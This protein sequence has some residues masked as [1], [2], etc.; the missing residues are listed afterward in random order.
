MT[1]A[2][3]NTLWRGVGCAAMALFAVTPMFAAGFSIFEQGAKAM[4]M[5][6]AFT[7]QA[8]DPSAMFHNVGGLAFF[9]EQE[10]QLGFTYITHS[11]A[12]FR[13]ANPFPGEGVTEELKPLSETP[14]HFYWVQPLGD[15]WKFGLAVN[16]PFGLVTEW[17]NKSTFTGRFI[18]TRAALTAIDVNPNLGWKV[19]DTFGIGFGLILRASEVELNRRA[20][21]I[22]PFTLQPADVANVVLETDLD[23]GIGWQAGFLHRM[24]NSFSWGFSYRSEIEVDYGGQAVLSQVLTGNPQFDALVAQ[25]L[26]FGRDLPA[27]TSI[28]YPDAA[29]FGV[30]I[31]LSPRTMLEVDANWTGW[32]SFDRVLIDFTNDDL[33]D[34]LLPQEWDDTNH[35]RV[36]IRWTVSD[37]NEWRL[38][39]VY[40]ETPQPDTGVGPL[41]P[42]SDRNGITIGL[43]HRG[44]K[45]YWDLAVMYLPFDDRSTS[46]NRDGFDGSYEITAWLVGFSLGW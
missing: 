21:A 20:P 42:D 22:N 37:R 28:D 1:T 16:A 40:D 33:D 38:G 6:G 45:V 27:E 46:T 13:G 14:P 26:P 43:G 35:Y 17:E 39:Y 9:D 11:K 18:S 3:G 12:D 25:S 23:T 34:E 4:G 32:S 2:R 8:D 19:S 24:N 31:A 5:A 41:L 30:A 7:A 15:R 44:G 36:G 29:S 10:F